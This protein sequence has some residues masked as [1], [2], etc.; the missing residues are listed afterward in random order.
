MDPKY[1]E[2]AKAAHALADKA[3]LAGLRDRRPAAVVIATTVLWLQ[4]IAAW[5][6]ALVAPLWL[7]FIPFIIVCAVVQAM[8][9]WVHEASHFSLFDSRRANDIWTDIF[10]AGPIGISAAAYRSRHSSHHAELGTLND[11]DGYPYRMNV[12]G[13]RAL[14]AVLLKSLS[15]F[16]GLWL[17]RDKY[18]SDKIDLAPFRASPSWIAPLTFLFFNIGLLAICYLS[19]R[20][21]LYFVL[22]AYP[23]VA[24]AMTLNIIRTVAEHQPDDFPNLH[25]VART[26]TPNPF[27]K[28][29][30]YQANFNYHVEHHVFPTIPRHN[31]KKLHLHLVEKGL[32]RQFPESIQLSGFGKF[33]KL[34]R[35]KTQ[36][37][38]T[39][40]VQDAVNV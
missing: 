28:W 40:A 3:F 33:W 35:N 10:F 2:I 32:Y 36:N 21:Y 26:T 27:E 14:F 34:S 37:D 6:V 4:I 18:L 17:V 13:T 39:D 12:R 30:L 7:V 19:G 24:V 23:V 16:L 29:M 38:F 15:G 9:L 11:M 25:P 8:L 5:M 20:W 22:W 1:A 31:L